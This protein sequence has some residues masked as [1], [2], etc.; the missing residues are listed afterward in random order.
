MKLLAPFL[1]FCLVLGIAFVGIEARSTEKE[2]PISAIKW[3]IKPGK[4]H[5]EQL[6]FGN[7]LNKYLALS[8]MAFGLKIFL[9][10]FI[11]FAFVGLITEASIR[12]VPIS[13]LIKFN[14]IDQPQIQYLSYKNKQN[15]PE[16]KKINYKM[17][18]SIINLS[19]KLKDETWDKKENKV[20]A[21]QQKL[22]QNFAPTTQ[23]NDQ[24]YQQKVPST[25]KNEQRLPTLWT[26]SSLKQQFLKNKPIVL[27]E[28]QRQQKSE[29][30]RPLIPNHI[31]QNQ[32]RT[33]STKL[34]DQNQSQTISPAQ[35]Q[36]TQYRPNYPHQFLPNQYQ[37]ASISPIQFQQFQPHQLQPSPADLLQQKQDQLMMASQN[38][39]P[40]DKLQ[41]AAS[42]NQ[43]QPAQ[44]QPTLPS[45][46]FISVPTNSLF[47][48]QAKKII[49]QSVGS[50]AGGGRNTKLTP[51]N[52]HS[53]YYTSYDECDPWC[54]AH[55]AT[56]RT[57]EFCFR[58]GPCLAN[59]YRIVTNF[60]RARRM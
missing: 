46:N 3:K 38:Q 5:V 49:A 35:S 30:N 23:F 31:E 34:F 36:L 51:W 28:F 60:L 55:C 37:P 2:K 9:Q 54:R 47:A 10:I 59:C 24:D 17:D 22:T 4:G 25:Q 32:Y 52:V 53:Y 27:T 58:V 18:N 13:Y 21:Q 42:P 20:I 45:Q 41:P 40:A 11:S 33:A 15:L 6:S 1:L 29:P 7:I 26:M 14:G 56:K 39:S 12:V 50:P 19:P 44:Y 57:P 8:S 43:L 16:A 48:G